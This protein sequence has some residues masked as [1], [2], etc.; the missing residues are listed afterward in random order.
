MRFATLAAAIVL[1]GG[2]NYPPLDAYSHAQDKVEAATGIPLLGR[3]PCFAA[4]Y[5]DKVEPGKSLTEICYKM[6]SPRRWRGLWRDD[7]EG[8]RFCPAPARECTFQSAGDRIWLDFSYSLPADQK[9]MASGGL[10][11]V[12][13]IGRRTAVPGHYG[14]MG[15]FDAEIIA[16][17]MISTRQ[18]EP[19]AE[20]EE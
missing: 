14:H 3:G 10:Y 18:V 11:E 9:R 16:D 19:P 6:T 2:C 17:R 4:V 7:F 20:Q 5:N 1:L 12:D 8:S 13:F 15:V